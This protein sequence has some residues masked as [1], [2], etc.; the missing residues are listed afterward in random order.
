MNFNNLESE[1][2]L[3]TALAW[4]ATCIQNAIQNNEPFVKF[5]FVANE[6]N[7]VDSLFT[8]ILKLGEKLKVYGFKPWC[9]LNN[10]DNSI[11]LK[12]MV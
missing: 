9:M 8:F 4:T 12:V 1:E 10:K 7:S 2:T 11:I 3:Q 6:E 5:T